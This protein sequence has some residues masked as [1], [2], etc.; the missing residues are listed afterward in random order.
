ML[1]VF[2]WELRQ[3]SPP[4]HRGTDG[5]AGALKPRAPGVGE[6]EGD[7]EGVGVGVGDGD[8]WGVGEGVGEGWGVGEGVGWGEGVGVGAKV[9]VG[10]TGVGVTLA[11]GVVSVPSDGK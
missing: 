5:C 10:T 8:G 7:G 3:N 4:T 11:G 2:Y 6:G 1:E 9:G